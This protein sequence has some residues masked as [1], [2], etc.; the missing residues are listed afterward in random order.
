MSHGIPAIPL[1]SPAGPG[2]AAAVPGTAPRAS[3]PEGVVVKD[4][5]DPA[6]A[7][8]LRGGHTTASGA[9]VTPDSALRVAAAWRCIN[10]IA[11]AVAT[12]PLD[13]KKRVDERT[14]VAA[15]GH[16]L[17]KLLTRRPNHWQT[18]NE[19]RRMMQA[20]LL[21]RGNA[22]ALKATSMG[23]VVALLP[24]HPDRVSV[25]QLAD[26]TLEYTYQRPDGGTV[27]FGQ[28]DVLHL[29]GLTL[30]GVTGLSVITYMR[31]TIGL[32]LRTE[33]AGARLFKHGNLVGGVVKH[34][35]KISEEAR[36]HL[37][38]SLEARHAG[39]ENAQKWM[40]LEEGMS[41]EKIGMT[42]ADSQFL[43]TRSFQRT[44]I[45]MFYGVPPHMIGDT[46]K[47]TSWGTGIE[48]QSI[49]FTVYTLNDWLVTWE[50]AIARDLLTAANDE[51][52]Y[53]WF[54]RN[55]LLRGAV[56]D[57]GEF[58]TVLWNVGAA[59]SNDIR[60]LEDM[61]PRPGGDEYHTP[62]NTVANTDAGRS[63]RKQRARGRRARERQMDEAA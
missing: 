4:L 42:A 29:R 44:D 36:T 24:M 47:S 63:S 3:A 10:L 7:E 37:K 54:N 21:L 8:F 6:V 26:L 58:Y 39:A 61:P 56:S 16:P 5:T 15:A 52:V 1:R 33:E 50:E 62:L 34:P 12:L 18:P 28:K 9:V 23:R 43:E 19:F 40:L 31:E 48:Q 13:L 38:E 41:A 30:D 46:A 35:N 14:R 11:G 57:R 25:R 45:A 20:H 55:A 22:Y 32:A 27:T 53:A 17:R 59:S 51:D 2:S 49:G 60:E